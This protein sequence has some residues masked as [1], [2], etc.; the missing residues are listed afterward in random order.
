MYERAKRLSVSR[1][2]I[3]FAW[4]R[5]N[6]THKKS[7]HHPKA[8]PEK[9]QLFQNKIADYKN[10]CRSIIYI[11][12]E[13]FAHDMPRLYRCFVKGKCCFAVHGWGAI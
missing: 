11:D 10:L 13:A 8:C 6:I 4:K 9:R 1:A 3:R 5:L 12:E 2:G 7:L